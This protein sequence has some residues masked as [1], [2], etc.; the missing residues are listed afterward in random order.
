MKHSNFLFLETSG[1]ICELY[2]VPTLGRTSEKWNET[3]EHIKTIIKPT[4]AHVLFIQPPTNCI[5]SI[6]VLFSKSLNNLR[7]VY[8]HVFITWNLYVS[9]YWYA[10]Q[11]RIKQSN[12]Q[13]YRELFT[14]TQCTTQHHIHIYHS[15]LKPATTLWSD[16]Y[17]SRFVY[18]VSLTTYHTILCR[19]FFSFCVLRSQPI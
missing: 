19:W 16:R 5:R 8:M 2:A 1:T 17:F 15:E 6:K 18:F 10:L 11:R 14:Y 13:T 3:N 7:K 4:H 12:D 9:V